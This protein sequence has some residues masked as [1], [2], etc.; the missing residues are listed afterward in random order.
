LLGVLAAL[1]V[2]RGL[3]YLAGQARGARAAGDFSEGSHPAVPL[4]G[5]A[6]L[7]LELLVYVLFERA[8]LRKVGERGIRRNTAMPL[9][10]ML[11]SCWWSE[12]R[13]G[14]K[15]RK[16]AVAANEYQTIF[17]VFLLKGSCD[18]QDESP[19]WKP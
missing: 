5:A 19:A 8:G 2:C 7:L 6:D 16:V 11:S 17:G 15:R 9:E 13:T 18:A 4:G 10:T 3:F 12:K 14:L 1:G